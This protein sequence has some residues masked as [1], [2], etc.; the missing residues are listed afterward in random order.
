MCLISEK[1]SVFLLYLCNFSLNGQRDKVVQNLSKFLHY[2]PTF[3]GHYLVIFLI[4]SPASTFTSHMTNWG[5][6]P[7]L[8]WPTWFIKKSKRFDHRDMVSDISVK[9]NL[10]A[11]GL[12]LHISLARSLHFRAHFYAVKMYAKYLPNNK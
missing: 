1:R 9:R 3:T 5:C 11:S 8:G 4:L 2:F 6:N 12:N 10:D 7:F